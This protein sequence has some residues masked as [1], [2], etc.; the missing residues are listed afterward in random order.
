MLP[1]N[2]QFILLVSRKVLPV[3]LE[4][5]LKD[6][7]TH[8]CLVYTSDNKILFLHISILQQMPGPYQNSLYFGL[9][10]FAV[11]NTNSRTT[12]RHTISTKTFMPQ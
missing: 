8:G 5:K 12:N 11:W 1:I 10:L 9:I 2:G 7:S 3:D 4:K 6:S